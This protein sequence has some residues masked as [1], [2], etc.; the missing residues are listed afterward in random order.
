MAQSKHQNDPFW[1]ESRYNGK[2]SGCAWPIN[3]GDWIFWYPKTR[4]AYGSKCGCAKHRAADFEC[5][6]ADEQAYVEGYVR[7]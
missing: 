3:K 2:C 6:L 4:A 5:A 7:R 1:M